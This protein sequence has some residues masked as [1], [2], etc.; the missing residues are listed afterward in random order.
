[1]T[2]PANV[3][4]R[5][6]G[7]NL[8]ILN[9]Q[10]GSGQGVVNLGA[11]NGNWSFNIT[12]SAISVTGGS[13]QGS[14]SITL[15]STTGVT[16]GSYLL[17]NALN[18]GNIVTSNGSEGACTWCD[19]WGGTRSASQIVEV[20]SVSGKTV[21]IAP[22]LY[23]NYSLTPL[24][25]P[26]P[27]SQGAGV[28]DLQIYAN[29]TGYGFNFFMG[30]CS[31][32]WISGVE[33]NYADGDQVGVYLSYF[34][35][36]VNSYFSN[37]Y[38]HTAGGSDSDVDLAIGTSGMLVE[39]NILERLHVDIMLEWGAAGNVIAY[40]YMF[41]QFDGGAP[42]A[43]FPALDLHGA[44]PMY[45]LWEGNIASDFESDSTWGSSSDNTSF[46][47]W[48][49][50]TTLICETSGR[51]TVNCAQNGNLAF[52]TAQAV[53]YHYESTSNND[54]G[55]V[56]G[57]AEQLTLAENYNGNG[58]SGTNGTA[59][60]HVNTAV[61][62]CGPSP[63]GPG[64][65]S[66]DAV[67]YNYVLGYGEGSDDGSSGYDSIQPYLTLFLHGAYTASTASTTWSS[68]V[69]QSLPDSFYRSAKPA[70]FGNV[71]WPPIGPDV[72]GGTGPGGHAYKIP[73]EVCYENALGGTDGTGS[74]LPGFNAATCYGV[75]L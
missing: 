66:Y 68:G 46:R 14:T 50:G 73:A 39:N 2:V 59:M 6:Q 71:P 26:I 53:Q 17:I 34:G 22:S 43:L 67:T 55:N 60:S 51:Q 29:N 24:A 16:V 49:T 15:A 31:G 11:Q 58:I 69:T 4:L 33:G 40:N 9:A 19:L 45:N 8:T 64:S 18:D 36:V 27:M 10:G 72:S 12:G 32:C 25:T 57:S 47:N 1:M 37:A 30:N 7:A 54:V 44:H 5:G 62:V 75:G 56:V 74:P 38:L 41:G 23:Y 28:E 65:L 13:A 3:S 42:Y 63:C 61:A 20:T 35:S 52:Q 48:A 21:G 70:W